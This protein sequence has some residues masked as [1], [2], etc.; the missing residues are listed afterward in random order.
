MDNIIAKRNELVSQ[1]VIKML[2]G[3][4]HDAYYAPT[5]KEALA[6]ALSL[7][8]EG[9][10]VAYGG[11]KSIDEIGLKAAVRTGNYKLIDRDFCATDAERKKAQRDAFSADFFLMGTNAI[12]EDGQ[13]VNMDGAGNRVAALSYGPDNVIV[14]A[15]INK[16]VPDLEAAV[17]RVRHTAAPTNAQRFPGVAPCRK[18]GI[19]GDCH[20]DDCICS[21]LTVTRS[22]MFPGRVKVILVGEPLGY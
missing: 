2:K 11:G 9:S 3:R 7:I 17:S 22:S 8:P 18:F 13:L 1:R 15:G 6:L 5:A 10:T 19:C 20:G 21:T 12:T 16:L 14:I 4:H